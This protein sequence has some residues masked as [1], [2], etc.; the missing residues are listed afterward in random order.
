MESTVKAI[1]AT[2]VID[3]SHKL[4]LDDPLPV[5]GPTR[6]RVVILLPEDVETDEKEWLRAASTNPAFDFLKDSAEDIY[7]SADGR[8]FHDKG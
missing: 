4:I 3:A 2:G 1:E 8:P 7:S 5:E 6:V